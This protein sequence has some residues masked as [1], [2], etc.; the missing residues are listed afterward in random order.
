MIEMYSI[1]FLQNLVSFLKC[2]ARSHKNVYL[3][4]N[5]GNRRIQ[6]VSQEFRDNPKMIQQGACMVTL[7]SIHTYLRLSIRLYVRQIA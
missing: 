6:I 5:L 4:G 2:L 1:L 7:D 3:F